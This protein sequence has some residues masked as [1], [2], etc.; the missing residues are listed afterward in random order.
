[1]YFRPNRSIMND[2]IAHPQISSRKTREFIHEYCYF[3]M[4]ISECLLSRCANA[5][6]DHTVFIPDPATTNDT[7][8]KDSINFVIRL[9]PEKTTRRKMD[10]QDQYP[11]FQL[12]D[13]HLTYSVLIPNKYLVIISKIF[14]LTYFNS[15]DSKVEYSDITI[16]FLD[17]FN[18]DI[19]YLL[20]S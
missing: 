10:I 9:H 18:K 13:K 20:H 14:T 2:T 1:M 17:T 8:D 16:K 15:L 19:R 4:L 5:G 12:C 3:V 6:E 7:A 11:D